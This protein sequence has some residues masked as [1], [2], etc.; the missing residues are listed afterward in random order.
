MGSM[1]TPF[2]ERLREGRPLIGTLLTTPS[3]EIAEVIQMAG[4]DWVFID[5]EHGAMEPSQMQGLLQTLAAGP[6]ALVRIPELSAAWF[7]KALD[8]GADGVIV[9]LVRSVADARMAVMCSKY[10]PVG[11]RS[12]G[13]GR[14]HGYG[15]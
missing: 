2:T 9:P 15:A 4:F 6:S 13:I 12:V 14:A 5:M 1:K 8:A 7:K 10:P 3:R 11:A